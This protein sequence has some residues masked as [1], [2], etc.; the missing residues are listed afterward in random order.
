MIKTATLLLGL[1]AAL[2]LSAQDFPAA[3]YLSPDGHTL[4]SGRQAS[5]GFYDTASIESVY[6]TFSQPD[7]WARLTSNYA[8]ETLLEA[9]LTYKGVT[10]KGV[11][12]RFRGNTSYT[13]TG[14]SQKKS[15][16]VET[17]F[18]D[19]EQR[20]LG[21]KNLKFNNAHTDPSF[22]REVL[23]G[24]MAMR[25]TP[26]AKTGYVHLYLNNQD[27]GIYPN[28]QSVDKTFLE[29]WFLSN[30]GAR[31][32]ATVETI[33]PGPAPA[34][35]G[36]GTAG[37]N[38]LGSDTN[39]YKPHYSL[40]SSDIANPWQTLAQACY[41]LSTASVANLD[42]V[43][44]YID[45]DRALWF[46]AVENV[47]TDDDS[48]TMK[49]KM[50]YITYYE[51]ETGRT[52][53]LEY[54]GN[55]TFQTALATSSSWTPFKN[56]T[57][58][59]YPLL[60]K[61]LNIPEYRQRYLAHYRSIL[62]ESFTIE[63][64]NAL[65]DKLNAQIAGLVANDPKK[66]YTTQAYTNSIP[67]LKNFVATRRNFLLGNPEVAQVGPEILSA[68]HLNASLEEWKAPKA[69][70][71]AIVRAKL[72]T[73]VPVSAVY[74]YY[75]GGLV[76]HFTKQRMYDDGTHQDGAANDGVYGGLIPGFAP[77]SPV[78]YYIEAIANNAALTASYLP[79]GAEH[80]VFYYAVAAGTRATGVVINELLASN[81]AD[82]SDEAGDREDWVELYNNN[83]Y[84]VDLSSF[85]LSDNTA[86][87]G[88]W[89][90]PKG[91]SIPAKGYLIVWCDEEGSEGAL[92]T[93][94]KISASGES[95]TLSDSSLNIVDQV[96][97]GA[98]QADKGYA[99]V[100]NGTGPFV[101]QP[102]TFKGSNAPTSVTERLFTGAVRVFPNPVSEM[103]TLEWEDPADLPVR[104]KVFNSMGQQVSPTI[105]Q[106]GTRLDIESAG[107]APGS[108]WIWA[109]G[110]EGKRKVL[111]LLKW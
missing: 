26:I 76:G 40:K 64:A 106:E 1:I 104:I 83:D 10:Y 99:R 12:V 47:F 15:F 84:A 102:T 97:F 29:E 72:G 7:Y 96:V 77:G 100:P 73:G 92:H 71:A 22:M 30:D 111:P 9:T 108:Y 42:T 88:K 34:R 23:Y 93:S 55:S 74:L 38:Y 69:G 36:D 17:D 39:L 95:V 8:S 78:R 58:V 16:E 51:P 56:A 86:N 20:V 89:A 98:Q 32:R 14:T 46:L 94:W 45:I 87:L 60:N 21:Y 5:S 11:G 18:I 62:R 25:Y 53:P 3:L 50:D 65:I 33:G 59:N 75:A 41:A 81:Q 27:W 54:D 91:S 6:L 57:N 37:M 66:L 28:V 4:L 24:R 70:Q 48:Y 107:W 43:R 13:Q 31:F 63:N 52:L 101:V 85:Y 105:L 90:F 19:P 61:L 110:S 79:V 2:P 103:F 80:D 49:G 82:A 109:A 67:E 68:L 44:K 35:W